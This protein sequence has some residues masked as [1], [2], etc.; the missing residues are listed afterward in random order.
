MTFP[1]GGNANCLASTA[2]ACTTRPKSR[3]KHRGCC[4]KRL[5][6]KLTVGTRRCR[7]S[8]AGRSGF[9]SSKKVMRLDGNMSRTACGRWE[10]RLSIPKPTFPSGTLRSL[11]CRT[12]SAIILSSFPTRYGLWTSPT[13]R[14]ITATCTLLQ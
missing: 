11:W 8:G 7:P 9:C 12:C 4:G 10:S 14:C 6:Q 13:L 3:A 5:W 2:P 1:S